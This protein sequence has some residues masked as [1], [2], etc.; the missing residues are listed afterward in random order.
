[1]GDPRVLNNRKEAAMSTQ[2][3]KGNYRKILL[4]EIKDL[5]ETE[6]LKIIEDVRHRKEEIGSRGLAEAGGNV[7]EVLRFAGIWEGLSDDE[8]EI[9]RRIV[10][11]REEFSEGR[12]RIE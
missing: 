1:V 5:S 7:K 6:I 8:I 12:P 3:A 11:D 9:F 4:E 2:L 10:K